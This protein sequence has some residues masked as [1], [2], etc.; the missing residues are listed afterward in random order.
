VLRRIVDVELLAGDFEMAEERL[1]EALAVNEDM[2]EHEMIAQITATLA[3]VL[4]RKGEMDEAERFAVMSQDHAPAESVPAQTMWRCARARVMSSR[5]QSEK[6]EELVRD[7]EQLA[8]TDMLTLKA[9]VHLTLGEV[10][11]HT[12]RQA[13]GERAIRDAIDLFER[14]GNVAASEQARDLPALANR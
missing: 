11:L 4:H 3:N 13:E 1:R 14:K 9:H 5:G 10:L 12:G 2:G 8:P 6:A 7:A